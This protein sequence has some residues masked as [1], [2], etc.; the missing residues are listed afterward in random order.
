MAGRGGEARCSCDLLLRLTER[1]PVRELLDLHGITR[2]RLAG[3][4]DSLHEHCRPE[5]ADW[6]VRLTQRGGEQSDLD[7]LLAIVRSA[8]SHGY[9]L[10]EAAGGGCG[11][12]RRDVIEQVRQAEGR[13]LAGRASPERPRASS[14]P[15][16]LP[17][18][19]RNTRRGRPAPAAAPAASR[20][21][22]PQADD[23]DHD[24]PRADEADRDEADLGVDARAMPRPDE[25]PS[26]R[27]GER[28]NERRT[29]RRV[30][31]APGDVDPDDPAPTSVQTS[32]QTDRPPERRVGSRMST[33]RS[34]AAP[35]QAQPD[36]V[37][38]PR[39]PAPEDD[40][41]VDTRPMPIDVATL[42]AL[43]GRDDVLARLADAV[44]RRGPRPPLLVGD[45]GSGRSLIAQHLARVLD[46]PVFALD[47]TAYDDETE[48]RDDLRAV[49]DAGG[50][51]IL[52]DLD[53]L[54]ADAA[55]PLLSALAQAWSEHRPPV[56]T[57]LSPQ[58][59]LRLASWLPGGTEG[60]DVVEVP[61][62]AATTVTEAVAAA[63]PA[64][65]AA[66]EV[67]LDPAARLPE[68]ARLA[69]HFLAGLA[70]P[71]RALDLLD[72]ACAR[73]RREGHST[74]RRETW[75]DI[76]AERS[77]LP[78]ARL[79][80][81]DD[82]RLLELENRIAERVVGHDAV[83]R[84]IAELIRR[85]G[86]GFA[87]QRPVATTL[88]LGPSGVGKT[89]I[90]KALALALFDRD[91]ALVRLDMS[92]YSESHAVARI[93]GAPPGYVG[94]EQGGAL[95]DPLAER[96]HRVVLLDEIEK[97]HRDVHQLLLQVLDEGRL[98]DGRG[99]TID[100]CRCV[101]VMTSNLGSERFVPSAAG[102]GTTRLDDDGVLATARAA[103]PVE[104]WN[105]IEAPLVL[106]PLDSGELAKVCR[107]LAE[108]SS[109]RLQHQRGIGYALDD[110]A[111][112][113]LVR[114]A[115]QD[116]ALGARPLRHW[117]TREVEALVADAVLRGRLR[118]GTI[119][120]VGCRRGALVL[121]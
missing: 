73:T 57:V 112:A 22:R 92:E 15:D 79:E 52:D 102:D 32:A 1:S 93:V 35:P 97:A 90:A 108:Q 80:G 13:R 12:I 34:E 48:L 94:Y 86:A 71:A 20:D 7:L 2:A 9:Q 84:R 67:T 119:A 16:K 25:R 44:S 58:G 50:I 82:Q 95:T 6:R 37:A 39:V 111:C 70:M 107:R 64:I 56:A 46:R 53:R 69:E 8:E 81:S 87:S 3:A 24:P 10:V 62:L 41:D 33:R 100:L 23:E 99:R 114:R 118:A 120:Q 47:A 98:T 77:G 83:V 18:R 49:A 59:R 31:G 103:F 19:L 68:V 26:V 29:V 115:G 88:L 43:C 5:P 74:V 113:W 17:A 4:R 14:E 11:E 116:P 85:G 110:E 61:P 78:R 42:P 106:H 109:R 36:A 72:L 104:L 76:A 105:R 28:R 51:A 40:R 55:P 117:I 60:M 101:L 91:D 27:R 121:N 45:P 96:P 65:L 66:H 63:A 75:L 89:E 54:M 21:A 38:Q 30:D